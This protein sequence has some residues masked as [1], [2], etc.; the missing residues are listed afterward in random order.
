MEPT[1]EVAQAESEIPQ[2]YLYGRT[3]SAHCWNF[4][5]E[6]YEIKIHKT[7]FA[8]SMSFLK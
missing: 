4:V 8:I 6:T 1:N 5:E 2:I 3:Y 7:V